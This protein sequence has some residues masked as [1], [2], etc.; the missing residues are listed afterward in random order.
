MAAY[1]AQR[2]DESTVF[3]SAPPRVD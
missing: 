1:S 2:L 3:Q